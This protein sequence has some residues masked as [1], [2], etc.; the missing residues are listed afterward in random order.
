MSLH[1]CR[2]ISKFIEFIRVERSMEG[3]RRFKATTR[4]GPVSC[5]SNG[6]VKASI[7]KGT[8]VKRSPRIGDTFQVAIPEC[9]RLASGP[10]DSSLSVNQ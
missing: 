1:R 7:V 9:S 10:N 2:F 8:W 3:P 6:E 5:S 4:N